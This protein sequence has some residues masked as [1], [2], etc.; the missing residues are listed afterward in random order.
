MTD[1]SREPFKRLFFALNCPPEQRKAIAQWR[2]A[3]ELRSGRPVPAE[4]FHLTLL[5]LGAVGVAQIGEICA[6]AAK[7]HVPGAPLRLALDRM[8]VW[9]KSGVLVL[10]PEQAPPELLRLVYA[11]EQA[12]LPFGF[13]E[14][15][16]AFRPHLTLMRD[17]RMP[18]PESATSPE[19]F[20]R[21]DRFVL[22]ESR[23][24]RYRAL[25]EWPLVPA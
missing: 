8:D 24:G 10:A 3:L 4:N 19:F 20:M 11:L 6:A 14:A 17:Y 16:K 21:A 22:F 23:K 1:E 12:M 13:E 15:S 7:V 9:R 25:A 2:S 18:V 5:F